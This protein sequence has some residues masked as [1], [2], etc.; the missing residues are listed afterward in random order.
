M[1]GGDGSGPMGMGPMTGRAA[2]YCAGYPTPGF[3]SPYGG[4]G[5]GRGGGR[6]RR[7]WFYATGL[8]GWQRAGMGVPPFA[9]PAAPAVTRGQEA[10]ALKRQA[11][12]LRG[13]LDAVTQRIDELSQE[14][15]A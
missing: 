6:G 9:P 10:D 4:G 5:F 8:T 7:R 15:D 14:T 11:D 2:G 12:Q 1:P 3:A 13:T